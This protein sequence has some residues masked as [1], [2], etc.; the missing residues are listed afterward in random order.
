M[1]LSDLALRRYC[2]CAIYQMELIGIIGAFLSN[3]S[4][5]DMPIELG[6]T[7]FG[8]KRPSRIKIF[9]DRLKRPFLLWWYW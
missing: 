2:N 5:P 8:I 1:Q 3:Q 7:T 9:V 6:T 4:I